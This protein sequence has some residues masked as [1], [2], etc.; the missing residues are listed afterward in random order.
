MRNIVPTC[1]TTAVNGPLYRLRQ[2]ALDGAAP[3]AARTHAANELIAADRQYA[4]AVL[5]EM[6][7]RHGDPVELLRFAGEALG[8][9]T[10]QGVQITQ[11]DTRD[12]S[13][14]AFDALG[15]LWVWNEG[16]A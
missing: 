3:V 10:E 16:D 1:T 15:E 9:L 6:A 4:K 12:M 13:T 14:P 5:L 8:H 7:A 11:F 2:Q